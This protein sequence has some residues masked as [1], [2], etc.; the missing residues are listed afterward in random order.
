MPSPHQ[1]AR[2]FSLGLCTTR[3][4]HFPLDMPIQLLPALTSPPT[5]QTNHPALT[6]NLEHITCSHTLTHQAHLLGGSLCRSC[7]CCSRLVRSGFVGC[8]LLRGSLRRSHLCE[9][10]KGEGTASVEVGRLARYGRHT[11]THMMQAGRGTQGLLAF[12]LHPWPTWVAY[13]V[14]PHQLAV[15]RSQL[16]IPCICCGS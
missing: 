13:N 8:C 2:S 15:S 5:P 16:L 10:R 11:S 7:L 9:E 4:P 12:S 14:C 3:P 6:L 1:Q